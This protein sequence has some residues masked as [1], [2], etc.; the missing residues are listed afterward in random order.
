MF[1]MNYT[2]LR[3]VIFNLLYGYINTRTLVCMKKATHE[4]FNSAAHFYLQRYS[5]VY[6]ELVLRLNP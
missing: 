1:L 6:R 5:D 2:Y 4:V 3:L